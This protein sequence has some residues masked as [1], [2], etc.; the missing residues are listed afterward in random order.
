MKEST[1]KKL[2]I[3]GVDVSITGKSEVLNYLN[4]SLKNLSKFFITT[5]NPEIILLAQKDRE[6]MKALNSSD[7]ALPDGTGLIIGGVKEIIKGRELFEDLLDIANKKGLKVFLL[8]GDTKTNKIVIAK[9]NMKYRKIK[10]EGRGDIVL[11]NKGY[12]DTDRD[13]SI[14]IDI[15]K[16]INKFKP[17]ILFVGLGAPKQE[18]WIYHNLDKLNVKIVMTVGGAFD[19]YSGKLGIVPGWMARGGLEW[20]WRVLQEPKRI[21]RIFNAVVIFP[22]YYFIRQKR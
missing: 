22:I 20:L 5:P 4:A 12:S 2:K 10:A 6:L 1:Q 21:K 13:I 3:L 15:L 14:H 9:I 17:D 16:N 19:Y 11:N 18:K 7:L 8:G